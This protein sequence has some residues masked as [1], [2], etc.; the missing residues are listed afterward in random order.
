M[1]K[2]AI[3]G[4]IAAGKSLVEKFLA[5]EGAVTLDTDRV[6]HEVLEN[7]PKV[8][9]LFGTTDRKA[10]GKIVFSDKQKLK[11]LENIIHP[12][13]K[14]ITAEFF[15]KNA[16]KK[17]AAVSVPLLYESGME[18][19][20]DYVIMVTADENIRLQR[21]L[22][23]RNL[24]REEAVKRMKARDLPVQGDFIIENNETIDILREKVQNVLRQIRER[25]Q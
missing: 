16:D 14:R 8:L 15:E 24:S 2:I 6:A 1:I 21:L 19:M 18:T 5:Q 11:L 25:Q 4:Q 22:T 9:E 3:T 23:T 20:F 10:I 12:E 7:N 17:V 13:V